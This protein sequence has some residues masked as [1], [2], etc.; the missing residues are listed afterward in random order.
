VECAIDNVCFINQD[1]TCS[2][3]CYHLNKTE[4][5]CDGDY[6]CKGDYD[7]NQSDRKC[8]EFASK[9]DC[10]PSV[11]CQ[12][13]GSFCEQMCPYRHGNATNCNRSASGQ[14]VPTR[15]CVVVFRVDVRAALPLQVP[16][17]R[18]HGPVLQVGQHSQ[19]ARTLRRSRLQRQHAVPEERHVH[20]ALRVPP[21]EHDELRKGPD[22]PVEP[23]PEYLLV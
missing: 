18:W 6:D 23:V 15:T 3:K 5:T 10:K 4:A 14:C 13:Q 17:A 7:R 1:G 8:L 19:R 12:R 9:A 22:M 20:L 11:M 2:Q 21:H 16:D